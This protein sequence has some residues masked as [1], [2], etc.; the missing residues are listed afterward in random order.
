MV[1]PAHCTS[2]DNQIHFKAYTPFLLNGD[3]YG[4]RAAVDVGLALLQ[5]DRN[6]LPGY[7]LTVH[8]KDSEVREMGSSLSPVAFR[9]RYIQ[10]TLRM[11]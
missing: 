8:Y 2:D 6:I 9:S 1:R 11:Y 3:L 10:K 7:N 5:E 4:F